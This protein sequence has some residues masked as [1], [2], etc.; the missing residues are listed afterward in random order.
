MAK[1]SVSGR[2][3]APRPLPSKVVYVW[4]DADTPAVDLIRRLRAA[5]L[6]LRADHHGE[7]FLVA[8]EVRS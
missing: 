6:E 1:P 7:W 4:L 8:R 3:A 2:P 5:D